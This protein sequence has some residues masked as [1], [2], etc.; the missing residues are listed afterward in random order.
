MKA[1]L[2][3]FRLYDHTISEIIDR[4]GLLLIRVAGFVWLVEI[5]YHKVIGH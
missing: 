2:R 1:V 3:W 4:L 5:I